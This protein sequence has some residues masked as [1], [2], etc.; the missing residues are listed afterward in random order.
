M[1]EFGCYNRSEYQAVLARM[2]QTG[3][4]E[5]HMEEFTKLARRALGF[6]QATL[7][8]FF[9][10]GLKEDIRGDVQALKPKTLYEACELARIYEARNDAKRNFAKKSAAA[11]NGAQHSKFIQSMAKR[12]AVGVKTDVS[13]V[14][15][16]NRRMHDSEFEARRARNQCYFCEA[17][18]TKGHNCRKKGQLMVMEIVPDEVVT[19]EE[20]GGTPQ[21]I[22]QTP[23]V[24]LDEP[25]IR[26]QAMG[27]DSANSTTMQLKGLFK[28]K[29]V[30]V[31]I[32]SGATHNFI[33][34][35]LLHGT[36]THIHKFAPLNVVLASGAK[37]KTHGEVRIELKLQEY[38]FSGLVGGS[39]SCSI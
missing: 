23:L 37:M 28:G 38:M 31:L 24:D 7:V 19:T 15:S 25:L 12:A 22:E 16:T 27:D 30:H 18:Y 29:I 17:P 36:K 35:H 3:R 39:T 33:H 14:G 26:L 2:D 5:Q 1:R 11:Y 8:T 6:P 32:D 4:V 20:P 21:L 10:E 13:K 9:I 34:P